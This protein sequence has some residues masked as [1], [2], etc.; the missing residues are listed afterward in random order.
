[1]VIVPREGLE[2]AI[3][4]H[5]AHPDE[6]CRSIRRRKTGKPWGQRHRC[7]VFVRH[8]ALDAVTGSGRQRKWTGNASGKVHPYQEFAAFQSAADPPMRRH[9]RL[10]Q[11]AATLQWRICCI[12]DGRGRGRPSAILDD[13]GRFWAALCSVRRACMS[14]ERSC[15]RPPG[16]RGLLVLLRCHELR[17]HHISAEEPLI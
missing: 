7:F 12:P 6:G 17:G 14:A 3:V 16:A 15:A 9:S 2:S 5:H 8:R 13:S 4:A 1:M 11:A 10:C